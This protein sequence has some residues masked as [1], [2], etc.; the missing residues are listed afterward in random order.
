MLGIIHFSAHL[1]HHDAGIRLPLKACSWM[2]WIKFRKNR[3]SAKSVSWDSC[4]AI[5]L[6]KTK[7]PGLQMLRA[8]A[9][10]CFTIP[11]PQHEGSTICSQRAQLS[12]AGNTRIAPSLSHSQSCPQH[13]WVPLPAHRSSFVLP[14]RT[15]PSGDTSILKETGTNRDQ[16]LVAHGDSFLPQPRCSW[17]QEASGV[18]L[19]TRKSQCLT[20]TLILFHTVTQG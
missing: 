3:D 5:T 14:C 19:S 4:P 13:P 8:G 7:L 2:T 10:M 18:P 20:K 9:V 6:Q 11:T 16:G 1:H 15:R 12:W 17:S